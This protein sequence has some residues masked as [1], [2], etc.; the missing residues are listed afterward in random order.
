MNY[1]KLLK[2]IFKNLIILKK[3]IRSKNSILKMNFLEYQKLVTR[4]QLQ[5]ATV[6]M[7]KT[8]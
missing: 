3:I 8:F 6:F 7:V 2:K 1:Q 4:F 5:D